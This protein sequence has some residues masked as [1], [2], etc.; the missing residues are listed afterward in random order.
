[1]GRSGSGRRD[2]A[3]RRQR[4]RTGADAGAAVVENPWLSAAKKSPGGGMRR[5]RSRP[6]AR[7]FC[8]E[9]EPDGTP[10]GGRAGSKRGTG[11][12]LILEETKKENHG[13]TDTRHESPRAKFD[14]RTI[15]DHALHLPEE[16]RDA[17]RWLATF[18]REECN[19]DIH[20]LTE[21]FKI[22][23]V[24][25][26]TTTWS[27][28]LRGFWNRNKDR[29]PLANPVISQEKFLTSVEALRTNVRRSPLRGKIPF[30]ETSTAS[31]IMDFIVEVRPRS[32]EQIRRDR[33]SHRR[34]KTATFKEFTRRRN[35]GSTRWVKPREWSVGDLLAQ[36]SVTFGYSD[37]CTPRP[38]AGDL[39]LS[40]PAAP[41]PDY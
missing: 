18:T 38:Q 4:R 20:R 10:K 25:H 15:E 9:V 5:T 7:K 39:V 11:G 32:R 22:V 40:D 16:M 24:Y 33:R 12:S 30:V 17:Y 6:R 27:K 36:L 31:S 19:Q 8:P 35:H 29:N 23:G 1:M 14:E 3:A 41:L 2:R 26:D 37:R 28:I 13:H 34:T 21:R